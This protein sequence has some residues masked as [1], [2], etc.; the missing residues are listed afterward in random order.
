MPFYDEAGNEVEA[1]TQE[2]VAELEREKAEALERAQA[3]LKAKDDELEKFKAK[4]LNFANLRQQKDQAE[5]QISTLKSEV[6]EKISAMKREVFDGVMKDH[7]VDTLKGL[8]G[9]DEDLK[10]KIEF[11]YSRLN[12]PTATKAEVDKKLRDAWALA[13]QGEGP[14]AFNSAVISSGYAAPLGS[15]TMKKNFSA[16][17]KAFAQRLASSGGISL[18]DKD[19]L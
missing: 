7:Y 8:A 2:Q 13:T 14:S 15:A 1:F 18:T 4:D 12:D 3:E 5:K 11:H 6:D 19:F 16:E 10:K 17:E 9:E